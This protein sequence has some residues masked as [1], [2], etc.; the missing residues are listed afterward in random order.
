MAESRGTTSVAPAPHL[1]AVPFHSNPEYL[2][3]TLDSVVAQSDPTW[4]AVV[5]DDAP[6]PA[7][8]GALDVVRQVADARISYRANER[9]LGVAASFERCF[10]VARE[11]GAATVTILHADDL[12]EP[13]YVATVVAA[14]AADPAAPCVAPKA[15]VIDAAG[16]PTT[17]LADRVKALL[18]PRRLDVLRGDVGLRRL[19]WGQFFH[20]P[21][22]SY[23][24]DLLPR[25]AWD[26]R[27]RQ[28]MDLDLYARLLLDGGS[29]R[30]VDEV[31]YRYRRHAGTTTEANS[32]SM[33]RTDEE[34]EV[35]RRVA[36]AARSRGWSRARR[37]GHLRPTVRLQALLRALLALAGRDWRTARRA[38]RAACTP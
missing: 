37:A 5:V 21:A 22:V 11:V 27:W 1:L 16:H 6:D 12:L 26:A 14:H 29:I 31:V 10:D 35:S 23:R 17:T 8:S 20:C 9:N 32:R 33:L 34:T 38:A 28:V 18:W 4:R 13:G 2:R 30:L 19:L 15:M 36:A 7:T 24:V 25:P 3:L